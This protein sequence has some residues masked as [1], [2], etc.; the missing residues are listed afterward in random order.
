MGGSATVGT[1][2]TTSATTTTAT[3]PPASQAQDVLLGHSAKKLKT[4]MGISLDPLFLLFRFASQSFLSGPTHPPKVKYSLKAVCS[5][6]V[7]FQ[8]QHTLPKWNI[9]SEL[10]IFFERIFHF[11]RV[12]R[13]WKETPYEQTALR[14]YFTLG[15]CAGL[16]SPICNLFQDLLPQQPLFKFL[17]MSTA[18]M[19]MMRSLKKSSK[20]RWEKMGKIWMMWQRKVRT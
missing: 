3:T 11:G 18:Q 12:C 6:G 4:A 17:Q 13:S 10:K 19:M 9:L 20:M 16:E 8:D 2:A 7:S 14:E 1:P 5:Y 15:W